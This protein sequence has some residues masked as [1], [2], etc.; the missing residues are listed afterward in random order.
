M[1]NKYCITIYIDTSFT[2]PLELLF[3]LCTSDQLINCEGDHPVNIPTKFGSKW[4]NR[5]REE[6][7][8]RQRG[9]TPRDGNISPFGELKTALHSLSYRFAC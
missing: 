6:N 4:E 7:N 1:N 9:R 3:V 5:F 8:G 2:T